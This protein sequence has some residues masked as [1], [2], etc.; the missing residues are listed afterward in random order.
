MR[1]ARDDPRHHRCI[2]YGEPAYTT[3]SKFW[4]DHSHPV[5]LRSHPRGAY[6]VEDRRGDAPRR[7]AQFVV[8]LYSRARLLLDRV[9]VSH[10]LRRHQLTG[11]S[12]RIDRHVA[13]LLIG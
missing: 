8:A 10:A 4:V 1:V 7:L 11:Q 5:A 3:H 2:S 6:R 12:N 9:E 13:I